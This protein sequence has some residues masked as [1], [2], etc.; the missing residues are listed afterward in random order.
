ME[1]PLKRIHTALL[2]LLR[3]GLW[4]R[5]L[6]DT[7]CFPLSAEEW[8]G[9]YALSRRQ[10]V[11]GIVF[12]GLQF[13]PERLLPPEPIV[14]KWTAA[15]DAIERKN[16][17]MN[18]KLSELNGLFRTYHFNP[19]LQKGQGIAQYYESPLLRECGD[20]DLYFNNPYAFKMAAACIRWQGITIE[21]KPDNSLF[22]LWN[23]VEVEHHRQ[24]LDLHN[25]FLKSYAD[26]IETQEG[27]T[28]TTLPE[29]VGMGITIPSPLLN[30]LMLDL[31]ILKHAVG[32]G[33]GLRQ[34]CD[35]ARACYRLQEE[36]SSDQMRT[37]CQKMGIDKW[38]PLLHTFLTDYLGLSKRCLP[39]PETAPTAQALLDI[40]WYGGNF[41][42]YRPGQKLG[43]SSVWKHKVHTMQS[44]GQNLD[45]AI[46]Y[47][48]KEAFWL[49]TGLLKG[50][51][52][53]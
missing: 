8:K 22:Y 10:T 30:L 14:L 1:R 43:N 16:K 48:P 25:P 31:H 44:F 35:M 18:Q 32:R 27:Y 12:R 40:V 5:E 11:T 7:S 50:Q 17:E 49:F 2:S 42:L 46:R 21:K 38:N 36:V 41:G 37:I 39:Y 29:K 53:R 23:G 3:S 19:I 24:L 28:Q 4:E 13:M 34:F 6:D 52:R 9:V 47:A 20:I 45:F 26:K 33:I 51:F 15:A